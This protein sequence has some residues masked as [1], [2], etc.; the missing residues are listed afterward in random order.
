MFLAA[1]ICPVLLAC[2]KWCCSSLSCAVGE[3][4]LEHIDLVS[5]PSIGRRSVAVS[6]AGV[7]G[8]DAGHGIGGKPAW[9]E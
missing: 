1:D 2:R 6:S 8:D 7:A 4:S 5:S 3:P 9:K